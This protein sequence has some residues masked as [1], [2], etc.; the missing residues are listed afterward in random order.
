[1]TR[2]IHLVS[3]YVLLVHLM[4][5]DC[6]IGNVNM[7]KNDSNSMKHW[8]EPHSSYNKIL[9]SILV[10][11]F[12]RIDS[13]MVIINEYKSLCESGWKPTIAFFT[14]E[15]PSHLLNQY[16]EEKLYCYYTQQSIP[17]IW[18]VFNESVGIYIADKSRQF[19]SNEI[20]NYDLFM[21]HEEDIILQSSQVAAY[22]YETKQLSQVL[23]Y[24]TS[25]EYMIGFQ[26]YRR[27]NRHFKHLNDPF[28]DHDIFH[29]EY[30]EETPFF[31]PICLN[32]HAYL[33]ITSG[34]TPNSNPHQA[35]WI[36]TKAQLTHLHKKCQFLNQTV[37]GTKYHR[38]EI[39]IVITY[40]L[41]TFS[42]LFP[43]F[44]LYDYTILLTD[45]QEST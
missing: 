16:F 25:L 8:P 4:R 32:N 33:Q 41:L 40:F 12:K 3:L 43:D 22:L 6:T 38:Y 35:I 44:F 2:L 31:K 34:F 15:K 28:L 39:S 23:G 36:L 19:V 13:I 18:Q 7:E 27:H 14:T 45:I 11:N 10:F 21:Y 1:M 20:N 30:F 26:R 17:I 9:S 42:L 5:I 29:Q 24:T 37:I